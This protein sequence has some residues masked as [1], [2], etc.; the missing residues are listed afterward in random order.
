MPAM[1]RKTLH[2]Q[3]VTLAFWLVGLSPF[4]AAQQLSL[5]IYTTAD[6]LASNRISRIVRDSRGYLWFCTENGLS[7]FDGSRFTNYTAEQGLPDDEVNDLLETRSGAY[8]IATGNG[9]CLYNPKGLPLPYGKESLQSDP[10]FAVYRIGGDQITSAIKVLYED[11]SGAVWVGA[12][13]GLYR[14]ERA[15]GQVKFHYIDLGM[16]ASEPQTHVVR[17]I[18]ED[19]QGTLWLATDSGLYRR[20]SDGRVD[21]FTRNHGFSSERL[22]GLIEDRQGRLWVGDRFGGL[23]QLVANPIA[24]NTVVARQYATKDG[25]G[26][27]RVGSLYEASDGRFWIGADCGLAELLPNTDSASRRISLSLSGEELT[28]PRV[29]SLAEDSNGNLWVGTANG[30]IKVARGGFTTYTKADGL[31]G[32][33]SC[34]MMEPRSGEFC[35]YTKNDHQAFINRFDG[36]RFIATKLNLPSRI[37]PEFCAYCRWDREGR[38]WMAIT[39]QILRFPKALSVDDLGRLRPEGFYP[40]IIAQARGQISSLYED[41]RG[42]LWISTIGRLQLLRWER[43]TGAVQNYS[44]AAGLPPTGNAANSYAEDRAGNL[45]LGFGDAGLV[46]YAKDRFELFT[47]AGWL[48]SGTIKSLFVDSNGRLWIAFS[49]GGLARIDEPAAERPAPILYTVAEGLSSNRVRNIIEDTWGRLYIGTDHSL[50]RLDPA[51]GRIRHFT[52]ADGLAN[53]QVISSFRDSQ[54]A[55]WFSTN[56]GLSRLIPE[57]DRLQPPPVALIN[58][59]QISGNPYPVSDLGEAEVRELELAP[60]QSNIRIDFA[61]LAFGAGEALRYQHKLEGAD[62]DWSAF[63]EQRTMYFANLA[64]GRYRFL[65]RAINSDGV[66][67]ETPAS[68]SFTILAPVWRRWWFLTIMAATLGLLVFGA[69]RYRVAQLVRMERIR[70]RIAQDL[71]DDI[72]SSLSQIAIL[73]EVS[74]RSLGR[75]QNGVGESLA[76]IANT[77]RDLVDSMNDIIWAINPRRDRVSDLAQRMRGF[78]SDVFT[79]REI[80]F[81]F[82]V[83]VGGQELRLDAD[84]RRQLYLIFKE[85]VNNAARHSGCTQAEIEFEVA[86]DRLLLHVRDNGRGF[87]PNG[88]AATGGNGNGLASMRERARAMGGEIEIF[89]QANQGAAVKLN[90]PLGRRAGSRWRKYLPV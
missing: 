37:R 49:Q 50:D 69:Y 78:A 79:A 87:D 1:Q 41:R 12:W 40:G 33:H 28:D 31:G 83:P 38:W 25:L 64:P 68:F 75:E 73:S 23:C 48:P 4:V 32:R 81:S 19:R 15:G 74:R 82:R 88:D 71:H 11:R 60:D 8:W 29:W 67:S 90:L 34:Y 76:Q 39:G 84:L 10:M 16:P 36:K 21:R 55:L 2:S 7:R 17:N 24:N 5:K 42:D 89:S 70:L 59:L 57:P 61:G 9:L 56:T 47:S 6:G 77:S 43:H 85:A 54:G 80:E 51:T 46:R 65:V 63:T 86:Q 66:V 18:L 13:R 35:V 44:E 14:L 20:F 72:G 3:F 52:T 22:L 45:W 30:A 27:V 58:R 62:Q 53:N 26:C